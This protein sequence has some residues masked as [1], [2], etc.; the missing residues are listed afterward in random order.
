MKIWQQVFDGMPCSIKRKRKKEAE[1]VDGS[2][3]STLITS[4]PATTDF[5]LYFCYIDS[6]YRP[7]LLVC[8]VSMHLKWNPPHS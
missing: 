4:D 7:F 2:V 3:L 5:Q 1:K 6:G 8:L